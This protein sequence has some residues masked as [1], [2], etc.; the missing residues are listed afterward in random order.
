MSSRPRSRKTDAIPEAI[1]PTLRTPYWA[2]MM[3]GLVGIGFAAAYMVS[4]PPAAPT[5][6][7]WIPG[8]EFT[9]G[10][11]TGPP[12]ERPAHRVRLD[13]YYIDETEVTN[14]RFRE[15][16]D[17]TGYVTT[18]EK[19]PEWEE[20]KKFLPEDA[21]RPSPEQLVP[22]SL[23]FTPPAGPV[24][25][26]DFP[27]WWRYVPGTNWKHPE[28]PGSDLVGR[29]NHPVVH[30]SF[31]DVEAFCKWAK[32]RL[33]TEAEWEYAARGGIEKAK[34]GW[35][36]DSPTDSAANIWQGEFP[37]SNAKLDGFER[38]APVGSFPANGFGLRDTA[39][40]V[41]EWCS[42]WYRADAYTT[43][44]KLTENPTGPTESLD[45]QEPWAPKR[46]IR[47][48]SFL[49]HVTYCESYR[50][51]ARRGS[52]TDTGLCHLGF[53]TVATP[54]MLNK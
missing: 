44:G 17:A 36:N 28:G 27:S 16:V 7:I 12:N 33:P 39:G 31:D 46:I 5:G 45:P 2:A 20:M 42:D 40:N 38:T 25:L 49:C 34:F 47:G 35:G 48:G 37:R 26:R 6:M 19:K 1:P 10:S 15:F 4:R 18:A 29:E 23:V 32:R 41:W 51:S 52:S 9:M 21:E 53:R 24:D 50:P 22:G 13:G 3:I 11:D 14:T 43:R 30:V 54:A 8:G